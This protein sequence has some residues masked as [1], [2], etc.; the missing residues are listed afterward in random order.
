ML[1]LALPVVTW[2]AWP[3]YRAAI[4][5]ARHRTTTMDTLVSIGIVSATAWS[6]YSMFSASGTYDQSR[7]LLRRC[8]RRHHISARRALL[9][10]TREAAVRVMRCAN[11]RQLVRKLR[12]FL[13]TRRRA[14]GPGDVAAGIGAVRRSSG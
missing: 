11:W 1:L 2:A 6:L 4:N 12:R 8:G 9:R 7:A 14:S 5:A 10:G 13:T 3:F